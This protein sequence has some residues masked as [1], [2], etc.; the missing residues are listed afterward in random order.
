MRLLHAAHFAGALAVL[1]GATAAQLNPI[2][3]FFGE[4]TEDFETQSTGSPQECIP[5]GVFG[6]TATLCS[7]GVNKM[8][9]STNWFFQCT[10]QEHTGLQFA[11]SL[12]G[13]SEFVFSEPITRFGGYFATNSGKADGTANFYDPQGALIASEVINI[14][15]DCLWYWNG[16]EVLPPVEIKRIEIVGN[17]HQEGFIQMDDLEVSQVPN[18]FKGFPEQI[19]LSSGGSQTFLLNAGPTFAGLPYLILGSLSGTSPGIPLDGHVL[20]L[21]PDG[22][23]IDVL[24]NPN[25]PPLAG[26]FGTL[27]AQGSATASFNV[28]QGLPPSLLGTQFNHAFVVIELLPTLLH[29]VLA[30]NSVPVILAF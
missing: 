23:L 19:S 11:G 22:Y 6:G 4:M 24:I 25:L 13:P 16:W 30:S 27:D 1:A 12:Q 8:Q 26:S 3:P 5:G 15:D 28:P 7:P 9:I 10:V 18:Y 14:P 17:F 2:A 29:V 20:P 21:N